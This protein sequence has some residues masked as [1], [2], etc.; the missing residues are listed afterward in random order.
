MTRTLALLALAAA[1]LQG[2]CVTMA[3]PGPELVSGPTT[4]E[5]T[6]PTT[7]AETT[8]ETNTAKKPTRTGRSRELSAEATRATLQAELLLQEGDLPGAV[9]E[10]KAAVSH[11]AASPYLHLR[12]GEALLLLGDADGADVAAGE[13]LRLSPPAPTSVGSLAPGEFG[14]GAD[15]APRI[16]ALRLKAAAR[17]QLGDDD[18]S[19]AALRQALESGPDRNASAML[20]QRLVKK[21]ELS[22]A[23]AVVARWMDAEPGA[24]DG[25]VA[26]ASVFAEHG[27]IDRAYAHLQRALLIK[28]DDD[29]ALLTRRDLLL[30]QGRFDEAAVV[31]RALARTRGD[32]PE[33]RGLLLASLALK[34]PREARVLAATWLVDDG[35]D[36]NRLLV[37]EAF[38]RSG[39]VDDAVT[40]LAAAPLPRALLSLEHARLLLQRQ[41]PVD[42]GHLACPLAE[43]AGPSARSLDERLQDYAISLCARAEADD[44]RADDAVARLLMAAQSRPR[45]ARLLDAMKTVARSASASRQAAVRQHV[46]K[47][48]DSTL[49][50]GDRG[51]GDR[52]GDGGGGGGGGDGGDVVVAAAFVL[53]ELGERERARAL[54]TRALARRPA[55][56]DLV[57]AHARLLEAQAENADEARAAVELVER[58]IERA[59]ADV[60]TLNFLAFSLAERQLRVDEA[61]HWA[62]RAV[63]L[64]PLNGYVVDT[65]GWATLM[66]GDVDEA[67]AILKRADQLSPDEGE[68][69]FHLA[70]AFS[71]KHDLQGARD[72]VARAR[73][74]LHKGDAL[75]PRLDALGR[76]LS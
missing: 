10:L 55:D 51:G 25:W 64:D 71:K 3:E 57:F 35:S 30:A 14:V 56:R 61:R 4:A 63:L 6:T 36:D 34:D 38:E 33:V 60:D 59:G 45:S 73:A 74:L 5:T 40:T 52:G 76:E 31:A 37:A 20:A 43:R 11:D 47:I 21:G 12:L 54:L 69:W 62:W 50:S 72:A 66:A 48:A 13:A 42:A 15:V 70:T 26:L 16:A 19:I 23:E 46:D 17:E 28:S 7:T 65:Y 29:A 27:E 67:I 53:D 22:A 8:T 49:G 41:R 75:L 18:G 32:G 2:A 58:L 44:G 24:V 39:L 1:A 68:I 9:A